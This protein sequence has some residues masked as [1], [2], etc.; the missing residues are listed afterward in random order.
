MLMLKKEVI[1][2]K[3][4]GITAKQK[5]YESRILP[6]HYMPNIMNKRMAWN[7]EIGKQIKKRGVDKG[8]TS[9]EST[10]A[11]KEPQ[12][13]NTQSFKYMLD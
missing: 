11:T 9:Q 3:T 10:N 5:T 1:T 13:K 6:K 4:P 8:K 7:N 2:I 12:A